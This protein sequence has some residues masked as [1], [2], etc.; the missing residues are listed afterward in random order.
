MCGDL[1][2]DQGQGLNG[3]GE[4]R[5]EQEDDKAGNEQ[6][7]RSCWEYLHRQQSS[8]SEGLCKN[9]IQ[10]R[11]PKMKRSECHPFP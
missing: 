4:E 3:I 5:V 7:Y 8:A 10:K 6:D 1:Y 2:P 9:S 11:I